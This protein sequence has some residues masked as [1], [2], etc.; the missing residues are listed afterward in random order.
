MKLTNCIPVIQCTRPPLPIIYD[1]GTRRAVAR[2]ATRKAV[3]R[4]HALHDNQTAFELG[5]YRRKTQRA[6]AQVLK[7]PYLS[8]VFEGRTPLPQ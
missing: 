6:L 4:P 5:R 1:Q 7:Q 8:G 2:P 3:Q